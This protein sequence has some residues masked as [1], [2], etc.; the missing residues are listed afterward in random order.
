M[1]LTNFLADLDKPFMPLRHSTEAT[2]SKPQKSSFNPCLL[3]SDSPHGTETQ[4]E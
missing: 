1:C 2:T 3:F 4:L